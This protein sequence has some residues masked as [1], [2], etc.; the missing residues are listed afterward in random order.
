MCCDACQQHAST[1]EPTSL[2]F[3]QLI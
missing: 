2:S 3:E 1:P